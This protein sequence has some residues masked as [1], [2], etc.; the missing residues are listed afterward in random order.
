MV[1]LEAVVC[2]A[3]EPYRVILRG[4]SA[5]YSSLNGVDK[6]LETLRLWTL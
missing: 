5:I 6:M 2:A 3:V 1:I 4:V